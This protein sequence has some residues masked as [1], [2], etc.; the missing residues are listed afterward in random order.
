MELNESIRSRAYRTLKPIKHFRSAEQADLPDAVQGQFLP[1]EDLLGI[2]V[3]SEGD[4]EANLV[5]TTRGI[6]YFAQGWRCLAHADIASVEIER[7]DNFRK[8]LADTLVFQD[9]SGQA[10]QL[11]VSGAQSRI[12]GGGELRRFPDIYEVLRFLMR[13]LKRVQNGT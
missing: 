11:P 12:V 7:G 1:H 10:L 9:T 8:M 5:F 6:Y 13:V 4:P 3:N 2:Y